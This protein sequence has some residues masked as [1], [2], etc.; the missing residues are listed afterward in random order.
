MKP[1]R[2][3]IVDD[4]ATSRTL[5]RRM[6]D[7]PSIQ[8]VGEAVDGRSALRIIEARR[9]DIVLM[10]VVMP[11]MDGL[12]VTRELMAT[13]PLPV[14]I[15]SDLAG[16]DAGLG[17]RALEA[18][19]LELM[20]KPI[21]NEAID[22]D[23]RRRFVR[24]IRMWSGVPVVTRH[25]R[26]ATVAGEKPEKPAIPVVTAPRPPVP[27]HFRMLAVGASTGGPPALARLL[28]SIGPGAPWPIVIVQHITP[29]FTEGLARWLS[30]TT[31]VP[32]EVGA[33]GAL[34][35]TGRAYLAPD[36]LHL[37][38]DGRVL[39]HTDGPPQRG[40]RPSVDVLFDSI[41]ALPSAAGV[42]GVILTGM[43][44]DGARGLLEM[45]KRG[46]FTIAQ[47]EATSVV[48][49]MPRAAAILGAACEVMPIDDIGERLLGLSLGRERFGHPA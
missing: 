20:R 43:G 6:L 25:K 31:G 39:R 47:D 45:R 33:D 44:E 27:Q 16:R 32:V 18:G 36:H 5:L 22:P 49:G 8:I 46:S 2:V 35:M 21:L 7:D 23:R 11:E 1:T 37:T 40:H 15:V 48:Y 30:E 9:P 17:F 38:Y 4:S 10:D 42:L 34:P 3:V 19:A 14:V 13:R 24:N 28:S 41:A 29:G 12:S 26:A